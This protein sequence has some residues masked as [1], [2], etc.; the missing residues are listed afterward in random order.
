MNALAAAIDN[1][2][3]PTKYFAK[4]GIMKVKKFDQNTIVEA[5]IDELKRELKNNFRED[6]T[7]EIFC[8]IESYELVG[9][10]KV[11]CS[12][13]QDLLDLS[14]VEWSDKKN[15]L[16]S[17]LGIFDQGAK[18]ETNLNW[19]AIENDVKNALI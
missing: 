12:R 11:K 10:I 4:L 17:S 18:V 5:I 3:E 1:Q 9:E 16:I 6:F 7:V 19:K 14:F 2:L 15:E 8:Q 13:Y